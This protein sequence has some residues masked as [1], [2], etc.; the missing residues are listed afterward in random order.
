MRSLAVASSVF[1]LLGLS[2]S[3]QPAMAA[4][5]QPHS[6]GYSTWV[7]NFKIWGFGITRDDII[8]G[9][10]LIQ[11]ESKGTVF[12]VR[13]DWYPPFTINIRVE[14]GT[15][16]VKIVKTAKDLIDAARDLM[17]AIDSAIK[18]AEAIKK[19]DEI[20][21][22]IMKVYNEATDRLLRNITAGYSS[23]VSGVA[24]AAASLDL[25][26]F[27]SALSNAMSSAQASAAVWGAL[28]GISTIAAIALV[29]L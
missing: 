9:A 3:A 14:K 26:G 2:M 17:K 23:L 29:A 25:S 10:L 21:R 16:Y 28:T 7:G 24:S 13:F 20:Y 15:D 11:H 19:A 12:S 8:S 1:L 6:W 18:W 4:V 5:I 22:A 27:F